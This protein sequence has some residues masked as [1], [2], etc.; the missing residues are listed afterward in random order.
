[1][2]RSDIRTVGELASAASSVAL[3]L[4]RRMQA[5]IACRV[6][7]WIRASATATRI[8]HDRVIRAFYCCMARG[9]RSANQAV[10]ADFAHSRALPIAIYP[11]R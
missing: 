3:I 10:S 2:Q 7:G 1:V 5:G 8:I 6:F 11:K 9:I 4:M